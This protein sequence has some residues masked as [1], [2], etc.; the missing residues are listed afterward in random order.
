ML[1]IDFGNI[2]PHKS[3]PKEIPEGEG[4]RF[5]SSHVIWLLLIEE[6]TRKKKTKQTK[7]NPGISQT[8]SDDG[9]N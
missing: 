1:K 4:E 3:L 5:T 8:G 7:P 9:T 6:R 2:E